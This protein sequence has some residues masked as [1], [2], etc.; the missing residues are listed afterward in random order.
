MARCGKT[1]LARVG[2]GLDG[3]GLARQARYGKEDLEGRD[4]RVTVWAVWQASLS[5]TRSETAGMV[6]QG[7]YG[8]DELGRDGQSRQVWLVQEGHGGKWFGEVGK[9]E[10]RFLFTTS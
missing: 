5:M 6:C 9:V 2:W 1:R 8:Q 3:W 10:V 4:G 7:R